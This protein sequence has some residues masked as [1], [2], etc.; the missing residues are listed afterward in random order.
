[1]P[2]PIRPQTSGGKRLENLAEIEDENEREI[3]RLMQEE[4][5]AF[6]AHNFDDPV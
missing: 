2:K 6:A 3:A 1:M 4:A 5:D